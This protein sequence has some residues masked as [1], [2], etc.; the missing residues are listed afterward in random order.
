MPDATPAH[1]PEGG[2]RRPAGGGGPRPSAHGRRWSAVRPAGPLLAAI[3]LW[4]Y[5]V[6]STDVTTLDDFGLVTAVHPAFWAGLAVLTAGFWST[7]RRSGRA[8]A[9]PLAHVLALL[10][11]ER[12]TQ[13]LVYPTPLHAWAWKHDAVVDHLLT[14][15]G[16]RS[17]AELG[18][19]AAYDQW[20]GFFA[21]QAAAVRSAGV[22]NT[23][24]LM[25]WW[26]LVS[27]VLV[28]APLVLVYR[29]FTQ[30][31][32]LIWT[33]VWL[34]C[35]GNWVGQD[36]FSPQSL[37]LV[38]HLAVIAL[39][40]RRFPGAGRH[41]PRQAVWTTVL[42][43]VMVPVVLSH[44]LTPVVLI[45]SLGVLALTRRHRDRVPFLAA[46]ALFAAWNL[47]ASLPFLSAALP[48]MIASVGD[49]GANVETG[50]GTTPTGTGA[51]AAS[52]AARGLSGA[53]LLLALLGAVRQR[54]LR[55]RARPLLLLTAV[56]PLLIAVGDYGSEMVFRVLMF[57]L[58]GAAFFAAAA[59]LP[60]T[61]PPSGTPPRPLPARFLRL[62]L[63][64]LLATTFAFVPSYAGKDRIGYFPPAEVALV[65][66][67][68]RSAP[69]GSLVV[70]PNRNHPLAYG[71]YWRLD[72]HWFL[73][74]DRAVV[75]RILRQP[76]RTLALDMRGRPEP[77]RSYLLFTQGQR[78]DAE[79]NGRLT[80]AQWRRVERSVATSPFFDLVARNAA[81]SVYELDVAAVEEAVR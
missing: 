49:I 16:L 55:R 68:V 43:M 71:D 53:V 34:F 59:L 60:R 1:A 45:A 39:V 5:A 24:T 72:H 2:V 11:M 61:G 42:I 76:A 73:E 14:D 38:L 47:T 64:V 62:P 75:D 21:L 32:R 81:G 78:A 80:G 35:A 37:A 13:A 41:G 54:E 19:M 40:L 6:R 10:V 18:D 23:L 56:P 52:W 25:S 12:A 15:G 44:Q 66:G 29:T 33:G 46:V 27:S 57:M 69:D 48:G 77:G 36:Y 58:P 74:E 7:V 3:A 30:D 8:D 17:G 50:Y 65:A 20:P 70:A 9:W 51:V 28:L 22:E 26:P 67:L 31:R 4:A 79:M 63:P